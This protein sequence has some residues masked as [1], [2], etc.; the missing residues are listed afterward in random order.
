MNLWSRIK[1]VFKDELVSPLDSP[2]EWLVD[3]LGGPKSSSGI[4]VN[5]TTAVK[6]IAVFACLR[7]ISEQLSC[8][9]INVY[10]YNEK[11]KEKDRTHHVDYLISES[12]NEYMT[13][14]EFW[15]MMIVN[16]MLCGECY[17]EIVR[18][19]GRPIELWPIPSNRVIKDTKNY[20]EPVYFIQTN[21]EYKILYSEDIL[22]IPGMGQEY[23]KS[24]NPVVI[25]RDC[26][27]LS[28]AA[29]RF[30]SDYFANGAHPS[31]VV[32]TDNTLSE[33]AF[34][35]L[36]DSINEK[37]VGLGKTNRVML[38]EEGMKYKSIA[39]AP[40][41]SQMLET[42]QHQVVEVARLFNVPPHKIM[43]MTRATFSN[44]EELNISFAQ[45]TLVPYC[46]RIQQSLKQK[47]F[48]THEKKEYFIEYNLGA[49][50]R[51][52]LKDRYEAY[53]IGRN[54][55]WLSVNDIRLKENESTIENGDIY[56]TPLNMVE[57]GQ[58][59]KGGENND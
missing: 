41:E 2:E 16:L 18:K 55:G 48:L 21:N 8:L 50:L 26:L 38:L 58:P 15:Q 7:L 22:H 44:I 14:F 54:W 37:Y 6:V 56:L 24:Y 13:A 49:L 57:S 5:E 31:G 53:A 20:K 42:R 39:G 11:G 47:L 45:D 4:R 36:K 32:E 33:T 19:N 43:D 10:K 40:K 27:G 1:N 29:E 12:P 9:P 17:A 52:K 28:I 23:L 35:R 46:V 59:L 3:A 34:T 25:A 51:G 30:A